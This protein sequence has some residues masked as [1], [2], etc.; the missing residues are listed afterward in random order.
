MMPRKTIKKIKSHPLLRG[1]SLAKISLTATLKMTGH[2][3]GNFFSSQ[4]SRAESLKRLWVSQF[5]SLSDELGV[6]KGSMMKV[7]QSLS[8]LG[9]YF[10]PPEA[11]AFLKKLQ[12]QS[13]SLEW[14]AIEKII[15]GELPSKIYQ[16]LSIEPEAFACASIGQVHKA[17]IKNGSLSTDIVLKVQYPG[18]EG[19]IENDLKVLRTLLYTTRALPKL[20]S[21]NDIFLEIKEMLHQE[22]NYQREAN[23]INRF[24]ELLSCDSRFVIPLVYSEFS[25]KRVL[26][27]SF[28][29]GEP[30]DSNLVQNLP[31]D[32]RNQ[33]AISILELYFKELFVFGMMQTDPH[34]G[35]YRIRLSTGEHEQDK[36]ILFDFGAV[37]EFS[38]PFLKDYLNMLK[39]ACNRDNK[40][41]LAS[42][43]RLGFV[44][45]EDSAEVQG[46]FLEICQ[47]FS[48]PFTVGVY[49]WG[50]SNLPT[51]IGSKIVLLARSNRLNPPPREV[52]FLDRKMAGVFMI[53]SSLKA[54]IDGESILREFI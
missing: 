31:Q 3:A 13:P 40:V 1:M 43:I 9:E 47:L 44:S 25:T 10:F 30:I 17:K 22:V 39:G 41:I 24:R 6:L 35:N 11:N 33:L 21:F 38:P 36:I 51:L 7:G 48:T 46:L 26:G 32:R 15:R 18:I 28:E 45:E 19:A 2:L 53:L 34:F 49:D 16:Q 29:D 20:K 54:Q 5:Q 50:K 12:F 14:P 52:V 27:L 8:V 4:E 37:K 42:G 23:T